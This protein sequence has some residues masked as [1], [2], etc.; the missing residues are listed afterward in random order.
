[1]TDTI[2]APRRA[3]LVI[4]AGGGI[5]YEVTKALLRHGWHVR[6]LVRS[7]E[8]AGP[9][10][11]QL[12]DV[13]CV[14]GD[15][16][17]VADLVAA[18]RGTDVIVHAVNPPY[19]RNWRGL[20]IPMLQNAI[21]AAHQSGAR[22]MLPGNV[23]NYAPDI[24]GPVAEDA[25]QQPV[26][27]KGAVRVDMET[28]LRDAARAGVRSVVI[29]AGDFF[30]GHGRSSNFANIVVKPGKRLRSVTYPGLPTVGH[31]WAYLPDLAEVFA[32][33]A[34]RERDL[35]A[36][37]TFHFTGHWLPQGIE[38]AQ[39]VRRVSGNPD[40]PIHSFPWLSIRLASPFVSLFREVMEMRYLWQKPLALD[41]RKLTAVLG[42]EPRT[43]LD[44]AVR[45]ALRD[46]G[47]LA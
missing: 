1:M 33:L 32:S 30:G 40:L 43:P 15:A 26:T 20:A 45:E 9:A 2:Q 14:A 21:E 4:G 41:N 42:R 22:L 18:A 31:G 39:A 10:L 29:R 19:Y 47:C 34:D 24:A 3:A 35:P 25:P 6:A 17:E 7:P 37:D 46:L 27:R 44:Q 8:A 13:A 11:K 36:F 5:G 16:M 23:Y 12:G 28:M 38:M